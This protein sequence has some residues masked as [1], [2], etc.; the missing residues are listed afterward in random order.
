M[1]RNVILMG[2]KT[3]IISLPAPWIRKYGIKK[4]DEVDV[5]EEGSKVVVESGKN[6][7]KMFSVKIDLSGFDSS[8][9]Y[10]LIFSPYI[11]GADEIRIAFDAKTKDL[12]HHAAQTLIGCAIVDEG[13]NYLVVKDVGGMD[14]EF[15]NIFRRIFLMLNTLGRE[16]LE[17]I[18]N[19]DIASLINLKQKDYEIN[20]SVNFCLRCLN[21]QG[22][23]D[24][25][26]GFILYTTLRNLEYLADTYTD[27]YKMITKD[28]LKLGKE[29][30]ALFVKIIEMYETYY[31]LFYSFDMEKAISLI[32]YKDNLLKEISLFSRKTKSEEQRLYL[33]S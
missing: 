10:R 17:C 24:F 3:Y 8:L 22:Y 6:T 11:R 23:S 18:Q 14:S 30:L 33:F 21:R 9:A 32:Q 15:D 29:F 19:N 4:G 25:K 16:G 5:L 1:K 31:L 20:Y 2:G 28:K 13:K 27:I 12:V 26:K 7:K